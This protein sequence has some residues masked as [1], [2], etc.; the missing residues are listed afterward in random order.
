MRLGIWERAGCQWPLIDPRRTPFA[1]HLCFCQWGVGTDGDN[2]NGYR[3]KSHD[4]GQGMERC[5]ASCRDAR[6][7]RWKD[8]SLETALQ[9]AISRVFTR[10]CRS[11]TYHGF[12]NAPDRS[13]SKQFGISS[14]LGRCGL[15]PTSPQEKCCHAA[16]LSEWTAAEKSR[17]QRKHYTSV[18]CLCLDTCI[19]YSSETRMIS[20]SQRARPLLVPLKH[21]ETAFNLGIWVF[22]FDPLHEN[23]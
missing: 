16:R 6:V 2:A 1:C 14:Y 9:L 21:N 17:G 10:M 20:A 8:A 3:Q 7:A 12:A 18:L 19:S 5:P 11:R 15:E 13:L 22:F 23:E 4:V